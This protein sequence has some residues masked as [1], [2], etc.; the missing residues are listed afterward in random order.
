[1]KRYGFNVWVNL[2]P[3]LCPV[4]PNLF[5]TPDETTIESSRPRYIL[6]HKCESSVSIPSVERFVSR[7]E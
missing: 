7:T 1:M 4:C 5:C 2:A 3:L 6:G